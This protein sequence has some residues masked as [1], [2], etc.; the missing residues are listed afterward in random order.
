MKEQ[1]DRYARGLENHIWKELCTKEYSSLEL[2][3]DAERVEM[4]HQRFRRAAPKS[5]T[6]EKPSAS[7]ANEPVLTDIENI[8][9][10][11]YT[12]T[13]RYQYRK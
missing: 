9:L 13:E 1:I 3:R 12:Q 10:K 4:T 2:I 8:E 6:S 5:G 7:K 11:K